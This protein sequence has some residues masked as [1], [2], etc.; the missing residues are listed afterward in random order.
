MAVCDIFTC[1]SSDPT[2]GFEFMT[3]KF[4]AGKTVHQ[5]YT[6]P[7]DEKPTVTLRKPNYP[8]STTGPST[9]II[10]E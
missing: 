3:G 10:T 6:R 5:E 9:V 2:V 8:P 7:F 1:G 4:N